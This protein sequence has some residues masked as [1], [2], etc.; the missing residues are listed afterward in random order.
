MQSQRALFAQFVG[1]EIRSN[2]LGNISGFA[3]LIIQP[4]AML[5]VYALVFVYIFKARIPDAGAGGFVPF[6]AVAFWPWTAFSDS[7]LKASA[8]VTT[9]AA[10]IGKV[11]FPSEL[12]P[13]STATATFLMHMVGYL[14]VLIVL[15]ISGSEIHWIYFPL[16]LVVLL[17]FYLLACA[18]SIFVSALQVFIKDTAQILPPLMTLWFFLTPILYSPQLIPERFMKW[19]Q[20]NPAIWFV[21]TLRELLLQGLFKPAWT[22][23]IVP[24]LT[25]FLLWLSL[26][27]FRRFSGHFEDFI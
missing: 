9:N 22:D 14:V 15:Q 16:A 20:W 3:W 26:V 19:L 10:L 13:M 23:L 21:D 11:A 18:I 1:R 12:L 25:V 17:I 7:I 5:A 8:S 6:L 27:L 24:L 4:L 2:Y